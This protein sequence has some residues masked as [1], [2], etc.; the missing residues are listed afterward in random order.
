MRNS[1][2]QRVAPGPTSSRYRTRVTAAALF[3][4]IPGI[5]KA[6]SAAESGSVWPNTLRFQPLDRRNAGRDVVTLRSYD[7]IGSPSCSK[8]DNGRPLMP[9][10]W[11]PEAW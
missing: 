4:L 1:A 9:T 8:E 3:F 7:H 6:S 2:F 5:F 10:R 11:S